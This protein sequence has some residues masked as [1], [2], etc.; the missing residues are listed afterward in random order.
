MIKSKMTI[1]FAIVGCVV[2]MPDISQAKYVDGMNLYE[3]VQSSP[4]VKVDPTG[5]TP[6][7][8]K[9][10]T[11]SVVEIL[12][13]KGYLPEVY[14]YRFATENSQGEFIKDMKKA[15]LKYQNEVLGFT[16]RKDLDG[17]WGRD[18][19]KAY[20]KLMGKHKK[21]CILT[22]DD[23]P[24]PV[25]ALNSILKTLQK[26]KI[27]GVFYLRGDEVKSAPNAAKSIVT[28][29]HS[30][31]NH[32]WDHPRMDKLSYNEVLKQ[33]KSTQDIIKEATGATAT[34]MRA[35]EGRGWN[36]G[37]PDSNLV[38]VASNL[39]LYLTGWDVDT[40]DWKKPLGIKLDLVDTRIRELVRLGHY[41]KVD[42]L[43]HVL[44]DTAND[45]PKL[46]KRMKAHGFEFTSY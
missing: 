3:Y 17:C 25:D 45:L 40:E 36:V 44:P 37:G 35:P 21:T 22:F 10:T 16:A 23:G 12:K 28:Q 13:A 26:N 29:G 38:R 8:S 1:L 14:E 4:S 46:I 34:R 7:T 24:E 2:F 11:E 19:E 15:L 18:T 5:L 30:V 20:L 9:R 43:M 31:Q 32:S 39:N 27:K 41:T 33:L 6:W 42:I